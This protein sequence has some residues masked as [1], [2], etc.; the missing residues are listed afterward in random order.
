MTTLMARTF[1]ALTAA[2]SLLDEIKKRLYTFIRGVVADQLDLEGLWD[3][4]KIFPPR[5]PKGKKKIESPC[6]LRRS[7]SGGS[8]GSG[9]GETRGKDEGR[10]GDEA[11]DP[12]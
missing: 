2:V 10:R 4:M 1:V 12:G 7:I 3:E 11:D 6:S 8:R 5:T 9:E